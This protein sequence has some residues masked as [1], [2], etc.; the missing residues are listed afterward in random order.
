MITYQVKKSDYVEKI[1]V[2]GTVQAVISVPVMYQATSGQMTVLRIA[3]D[4]AFVNKGDTICVLSSQALESSYEG[5]LTSIEKLEAELKRTEADNQLNIA[6][7]EAQLATSEAQL[8]ISSLDSLKMKFETE[9]NQRLLKLEYA[10]SHDRK[11][12]D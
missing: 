4:G 12:E 2:P 11:K 5:Q 1:T 6:L 7:L 3:A 8:K 9:T 10:E